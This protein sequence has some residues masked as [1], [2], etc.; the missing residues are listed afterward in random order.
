MVDKITTVSKTKCET[1]VGRLSD[2]DMVRVNRAVLVFLGL[3][4]PGASEHRRTD[5]CLCLVGPAAV[6]MS[7]AR[8]SR[9][10]KRGVQ[11]RL[12][13]I[14]SGSLLQCG[15][16]GDEH[17]HSRVALSGIDKKP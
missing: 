13:A 17:C 5:F 15:H 6:S 4:G 7:G 11:S 2:E 1:R 9:I 3:A 8:S 16:P 12:V 14:G 10:D